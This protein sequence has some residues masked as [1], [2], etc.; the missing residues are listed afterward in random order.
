M[1]IRP[2]H[3][4]PDP[5]QEL[6]SSGTFVAEL[7]DIRH[8]QSDPKY[9]GSKPRLAFCFRINAPGNPGAH[10]K[11]V[12]TIVTASIYSS[13]QTGK[14]SNLVKL[15]RSMGIPNPEKGCDPDTLIGRN[16]VVICELWE[17][18]SFVQQATPAPGGVGKQAGKPETFKPSAVQQPRE[19]SDIPF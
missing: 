7:E 15:L 19:D 10:N 8:C 3:D 11:Y 14:E 12:V 13:K 17:G 16:F 2:S 1:F 4:K 6:R 18:K 9:P 5:E